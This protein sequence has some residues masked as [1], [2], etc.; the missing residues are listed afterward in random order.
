M[1]SGYPLIF[2]SSFAEKFLPINLSSLFVSIIVWSCVLTNTRS[3]EQ[4]GE[5]RTA[6][7]KQLQRLAD[8]FNTKYELTGTPYVLRVSN[9][10]GID[11]QGALPDS[12][13]AAVKWNPRQGLVADW[14][15]GAATVSAFTV[16]RVLF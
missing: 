16:W 14:P 13:A 7:A 11:D 15:E 2:I 1:C 9:T 3:L 5:I 4:A 8:A 6:V 10:L 12:D